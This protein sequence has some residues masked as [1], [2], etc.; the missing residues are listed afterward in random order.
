MQLLEPSDFI[1]GCAVIGCL[2][3]IAFHRDGTISSILMTIC[4]YY[5]GSKSARRVKT[6]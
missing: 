2:T 4:G 1:A 5:F 3:L 6:K